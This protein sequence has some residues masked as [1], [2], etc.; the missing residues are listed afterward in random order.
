MKGW[1]NKCIIKIKGVLWLYPFI[2]S[3]IDQC[4]SLRDLTW[5]IKGDTEITLKG[6]GCGG[7]KICPQPLILGD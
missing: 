5:E 3:F 1:R 2:L 6:Y 7:S 4:L